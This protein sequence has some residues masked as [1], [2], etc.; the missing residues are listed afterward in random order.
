MAL[1][2]Y[3]SS[4]MLKFGNRRRKEW[5][6]LNFDSMYREIL[7]VFSRD[8]QSLASLLTEF[9]NVSETRFEVAVLSYENAVASVLPLTC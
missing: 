1:N 2:E 5:D 6:V 7:S 8:L 9:S 3:S 4:K